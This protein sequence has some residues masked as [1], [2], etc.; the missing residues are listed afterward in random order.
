MEYIIVGLIL[1]GI[2][3]NP[4]LTGKIIV[5]IIKFIWGLTVKV[6]KFLFKRF[7]V[8]DKTTKESINSIKNQVEEIKNNE[9]I[10]KSVKF[11]KGDFF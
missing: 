2:L 8:V 11:L 3:T 7:F 9:G 4:F 6:F 1:I 10:I 5:G